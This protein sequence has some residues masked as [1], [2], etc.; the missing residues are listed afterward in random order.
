MALKLH[1]TDAGGVCVGGNQLVEQAFNQGLDLVADP[2][3]VVDVA[4]P[5]RV[6]RPSPARIRRRTP[7]SGPRQCGVRLPARLPAARSWRSPSPRERD[8]PALLG[9]GGSKL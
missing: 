6:A 7:G 5:S 9:P 3:D 1:L 2:A 8:R 4:R